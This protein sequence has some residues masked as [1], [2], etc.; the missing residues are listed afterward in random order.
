MLFFC[1]H[2]RRTSHQSTTKRACR[3]H[4]L[5]HSTKST[6][7]HTP[8]NIRSTTN[9]SQQPCRSNL[10]PLISSTSICAQKRST[11]DGSK[12][13][14]MDKTKQRHLRRQSRPSHHIP[15]VHNDKISVSAEEETVILAP[16]CSGYHTTKVSKTDG[17]GS[18]PSVSSPSNRRLALG[19]IVAKSGR[20]ASH[21]V[22]HKVWPNSCL[23]WVDHYTNMQASA[24]N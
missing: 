16:V 10:L 1:A 14:A 24:S 20:R 22:S 12:R 17:S 2:H 9:H 7:S 4:L 5:V 13:D 8:Q 23:Y 15:T 3:S 11:T 19:S 18:L 21:N 6:S